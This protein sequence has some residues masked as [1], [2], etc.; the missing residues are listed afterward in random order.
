[1][2]TRQ[3]ARIHRRIS[4]R[5]LLGAG[6]GLL[7]GGS[8]GAGGG[9]IFSSIGTPA[10]WGA[11]VFGC[12]FGLGIGMLLLGYSALES[13]DPGDE[14]SDTVRPVRDRAE[15]TREEDPEPT[16]SGDQPGPASDPS[17]THDP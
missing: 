15:L 1:V 6:V 8:L 17:T 5:L 4:S 12:I 11:V 7:V 2:E 10:F 16:T 13:P 14:P 3:Q 9:L